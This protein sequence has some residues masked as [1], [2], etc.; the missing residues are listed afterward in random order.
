[1]L[2]HHDKQSIQ[3]PFCIR[4]LSTE[5]EPNDHNVDIAL[6]V[7]GSDFPR[8]NAGDLEGGLLSRMLNNRVPG[9][10]AYIVAFGHCSLRKGLSKGATV[11]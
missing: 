11:R 10:Q 2:Y 9:A 6:L 1:M 5:H 7:L 8:G 4:P 3:Y